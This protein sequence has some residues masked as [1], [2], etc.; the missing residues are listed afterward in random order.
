MIK[1]KI[2]YKIWY[3]FLNFYWSDDADNESDDE[4][5]DY[6]SYVVDNNEDDYV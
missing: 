6:Y 2:T 4:D 3:N 5:N 1:K